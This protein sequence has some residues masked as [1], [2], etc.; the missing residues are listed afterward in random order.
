M[1]EALF[2]CG[3]V[4]RFRLQHLKK[5]I[6]ALRT[7]T[8]HVLISVSKVTVNISFHDAFG[9][10][11]VKQVI[12]DQKLVKN[13]AKREYVCFVRVTRPTEYFWSHEARRATFSR[14]CLI[15]KSEC[16]KTEIRYSDFKIC[17]VFN[18]RDENVF[19][20]YVTMDYFLA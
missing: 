20:F 11:S 14:E 2:R 9:S 17:F 10:L 8:F 15:L 16:S 7:H 1:R 19:H 12:T 18:P 3:P 13:S 4:L 5:Q 6:L